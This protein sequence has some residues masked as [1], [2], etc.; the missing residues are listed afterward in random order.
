MDHEIV[1][2]EKMTEKYLLAELDDELR[3]EFEEHY[4]DC[5]ECAQDV[6]AAS[7]FVEQS[8]AILAKEAAVLEEGAAGQN[9]SKPGGR[10][11]FVWLR[12]A[13]AVPVFALMLIV[14]GYQNFVTLPR[15][16]ETANNPK[17]LPAVTVNLLTYG[18]NST[19]LAVRPGGGFLLNVIVPPGKSYSAYRVELYNPAGELESKLPV[20][21][22]A[23]DTWSIQFPVANR[24]DGT[25]RVKVYG[26]TADGKDV[27]VGSNSFVLQ[28]QK[29]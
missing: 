13:F 20:S 18:S 9:R 19:A 26:V 2:R 22:S 3:D 16:S 12:P 17:L 15:L 23:N 25:Y 14:I 27:E 10:G 8:K 29:D 11:W 1:V 6:R 5:V 21:T 24:Q 7:A 28:V 4:F